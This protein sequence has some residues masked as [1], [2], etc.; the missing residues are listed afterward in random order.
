MQTVQSNDLAGGDN[1]AQ[2]AHMPANHNNQGPYPLKNESIN[3]GNGMFSR[4]LQQ[5]AARAAISMS[6]TKLQ[7]I[8][9]GP[10]SRRVRVPE[11]RNETV[12][13]RKKAKDKGLFKPSQVFI[14]ACYGNH[15]AKQTRNAGIGWAPTIETGLT[16]TSEPKQPQVPL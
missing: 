13:P 2:I 9:A 3:L 8:I 15:A 7:Y 6:G 10:M 4:L 12:Q 14:L 1:K 16:E 11:V 5:T